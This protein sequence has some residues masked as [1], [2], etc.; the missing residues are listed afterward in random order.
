[1]EL[2]KRLDWDTEHFEML[3]GRCESHNYSPVISNSDVIAYDMISF[4]GT[5]KFAL[6]DCGTL[7]KVTD[8]VTYE[9]PIISI[10]SDAPRLTYIENSDELKNC[11]HDFADFVDSRFYQDAR[12]DKE[13]VGEMYVNWIRNSLNH[14]SKSSLLFVNETSLELIGIIVYSI[15]DKVRLELIN[16]RSNFRGLGYG[17]EM[18]NVF[19][20]FLFGRNIESYYVGTQKDNLSANRLYTKMGGKKIEEISIHHWFKE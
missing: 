4:F 20:R 9:V 19:Q 14:K 10:D 12:F 8:Q 7:I 17:R 5:F 18:L 16:V 1:M 3:C 13:K 15:T 6:E 11:A 2:I